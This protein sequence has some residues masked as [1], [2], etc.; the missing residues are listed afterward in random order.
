MYILSISFFGLFLKFFNS[1]LI[2][3]PGEI[4]DCPD[5]VDFAS[6]V[7]DEN[8]VDVIAWIRIWRIGNRNFLDSLFFVALL[9]LFFLFDVPPL[10]L[11]GR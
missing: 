6:A 8:Y 5:I 1:P 2:D 4:Q 10:P 11:V 3:L 9:F 7:P